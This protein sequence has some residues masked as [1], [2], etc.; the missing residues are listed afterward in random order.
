M[1]PYYFDISKGFRCLTGKNAKLCFSFASIS[2]RPEKLIH[3]AANMHE[4]SVID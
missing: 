2:K 3:D 1:F 4:L